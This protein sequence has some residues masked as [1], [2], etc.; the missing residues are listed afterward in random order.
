MI[1]MAFFLALFAPKQLP[2]N[3]DPTNAPRI[4]CHA[5]MTPEQSQAAGCQ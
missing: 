3:P 1:S 5:Q 2:T 4:E